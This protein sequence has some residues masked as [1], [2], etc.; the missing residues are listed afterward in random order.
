MWHITQKMTLKSTLI[1]HRSGNNYTSDSLTLTIKGKTKLIDIPFTCTQ[2]GNVTAFKGSFKI[3]RLD[4]GI[5]STSLV[6]SDEVSIS[7]DVEVR[8]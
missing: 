6:L 7:V 2:A 4:Y 1:K 5:G 3:N 8:D